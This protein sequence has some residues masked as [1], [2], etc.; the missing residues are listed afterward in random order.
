[1]S[2]ISSILITTLLTLSS[3]IVWAA[4]IEMKTHYPA[5]VGNYQQIK[6]TKW[7]EALHTTPTCA[8]TS[9]INNKD[10]GRI[11]YGAPLKSD[12][13]GEFQLL[14]LYYCQGGSWFPFSGNSDSLWTRTSD[15]TYRLYPT[16]LADNVGIGTQTPVSLL[17]VGGGGIPSPLAGINVATGGASYVSVS[18]GTTQ[19]FLGA[20][21]SGSGVIGTYGANDFVIQTANTERMRISAAG[22]ITIKNDLSTTGTLT[23]TGNVGI[24]TSL[25]PVRPLEVNS[26][27]KFTSTNTTD[28]IIGYD[29]TKTDGL[30]ITGIN[31]GSGNRKIT[32]SGSILQQENNA[33]NQFFNNTIFSGNVA[34]GTTTP[35]AS[36]GLT[37]QNPGS[38]YPYLL[39]VVSGRIRTLHID[40]KNTGSTSGTLYLQYDTLGNV[41]I[42]QNQTANL[43]VYGDIT[44]SGSV[45][46]NQIKTNG[47][48][49]ST[50]GSLY[51]S[52]GTISGSS[53]TATNNITVIASLTD[54][55]NKGVIS[56]RND[57]ISTGTISVNSINTGSLKAAKNPVTNTTGA[58]SAASVSATGDISALSG[59]NVSGYTI[60]ATAGTINLGDTSVNGIIYI[61]GKAAVQ[62]TASSL[63]LNPYSH[64]SGGV[65]I[66]GNLT[67][68]GTMDIQTIT[69]TGD[70]PALN[71]VLVSSD[72][73]GTGTWKPFSE[74][75]GPTGD[76]GPTGYGP[77]GPTGPTGPD[78]ATGATGSV[79]SITCG[80][81]SGW[82]NFPTDNPL[83]STGSTRQNMIDAHA[84]G[85]CY[86]YSDHGPAQQKWKTGELVTP[87]GLAS[88]N[89]VVC[90][91]WLSNS[92]NAYNESG[93]SS[94]LSGN[95]N[96]PF[97]FYACPY[98]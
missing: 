11:F 60:N 96:H 81:G 43:L 19:A 30:F 42:G 13:S 90:G 40:G 15:N 23:I 52:L 50:N 66:P 39:D 64:F 45:Q 80:W 58:I 59:G 37:I 34:I 75:K 35:P 74:M 56:A 83:N 10:D 79:T 61:D 47:T 6:L 88:L 77:T 20:D 46:G 1:M 87:Y 18:D 4:Q 92:T 63:Q 44:A 21:L 84:T 32:L 68:G 65:N 16:N 95:P 27:I 25:P 24:K 31:D 5:P 62:G 3:S 69:I 76:T 86:W 22:D 55:N 29:K 2:K 89:I 51:A 93:D 49:T 57:I 7:S 26:S 71:S 70:N 9:T 8:D 41:S 12:H 38:G 85:L 48:I 33:T 94:R 28:G 14:G 91:N 97:Y 67:V 82:G 73:S 53:V 36:L 54:P 98:P 72:T 17:T 78:G